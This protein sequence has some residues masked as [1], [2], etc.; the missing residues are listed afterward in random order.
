[1][2]R[3]LD[4][5]IS[6]IQEREGGVADLGDGK[7]LT[8]WGQTEGWLQQ[9]N[10]PIPKTAEEAATNWARWL[11]RK[12][13]AEVIYWDVTVGDLVADFAVHSGEGE[14]IAAL[15]RA[16]GVADDGV[17]GPITLSALRR[18]NPESVAKRI[19]ADRTRFLGRL[20]A[21]TTTDRRKFARGWMNRIADQIE[22]LP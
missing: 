12:R 17:I 13:I 20:L 10:L 5:V 15:Q 11:A 21:S 19:L 8:R 6:R 14:G 4:I 18:T 3:N 16:I 22:A 2:S 1:M 9:H 7:G